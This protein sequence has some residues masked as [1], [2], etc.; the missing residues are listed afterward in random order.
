MMQIRSNYGLN[1][2][3]NGLLLPVIRLLGIYD[4]DR[5]AIR[6]TV[7]TVPRGCFMVKYIPKNP[8]K[9][10]IRISTVGNIVSYG[11]ML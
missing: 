3:G 7:K 9:D 1:M 2:L 6:E 11:W 4:S 8:Q 10:I 5:E